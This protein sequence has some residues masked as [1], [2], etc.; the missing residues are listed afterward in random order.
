M[1]QFGENLRRVRE[2]KRFTKT[3]MAKKLGIKLPSYSLYESGKREPSLTNLQ[4]IAKTLNTPVDEL[5]NTA[6]DEFQICA[7]FWQKKHHKIT[8]NADESIIMTLPVAG[9]NKTEF[10]DNQ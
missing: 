6:L 7:D 5:L 10:R 4:I 1:L 3:Q 8:L 9:T 2:S